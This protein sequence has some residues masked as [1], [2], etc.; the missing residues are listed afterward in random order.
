MRNAVVSFTQRLT[1]W[2]QQFSQNAQVY[3]TKNYPLRGDNRKEH[4]VSGPPVYMLIWWS[5]PYHDGQAKRWY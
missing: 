1:Q 5:T 4:Y 3:I 2:V